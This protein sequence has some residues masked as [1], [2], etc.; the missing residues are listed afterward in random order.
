M[1]SEKTEA[2]AK[3]VAL[4]FW[5]TTAILKCYVDLPS[6]CITSNWYVPYFIHLVGRNNGRGRMWNQNNW[7]KAPR[8]RDQVSG[9]WREIFPDK[10]NLPVTVSSYFLPSIVSVYLRSTVEGC[11]M[12]VSISPELLS[13]SLLYKKKKKKFKTNNIPIT[14]SNVQTMW[15]THTL[16]EFDFPMVFFFPQ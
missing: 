14:K 7:K 5:Q 13:L 12:T 16:Q 15:F 3:L 2:D 11:W 9:R 1:V 10:N 8:E 6:F 4:T